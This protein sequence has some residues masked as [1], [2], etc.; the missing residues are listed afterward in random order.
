MMQEED[1]AIWGNDLLLHLCCGVIQKLGLWDNGIFEFEFFPCRN[2]D[3]GGVGRKYSQTPIFP[4][5]VFEEE[6]NRHKEEFV[7]NYL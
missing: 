7:I 5:L 3:F 6:Q 2:R 1:G 4:F